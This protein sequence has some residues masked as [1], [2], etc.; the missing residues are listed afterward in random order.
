MLFSS[1]NSLLLLLLLLLS[2][3]AAAAVALGGGGAAGEFQTRE[4]MVHVVV[5]LETMDD[6][7]LGHGGG[8]Q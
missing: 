5:L 7:R 8:H 2:G 1:S 3:A 4:L 6:V